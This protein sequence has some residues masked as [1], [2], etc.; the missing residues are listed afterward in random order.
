MPVTGR[1]LAPLSRGRSQ[2]YCRRGKKS[3]KQFRQRIWHGGT[4]ACFD[5][6]RPLTPSR[7]RNGMCFRG[8]GSRTRTL[9]V[10]KDLFPFPP[11]P[12]GWAPSSLLA[13]SKEHTVACYKEG[14][15]QPE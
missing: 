10:K 5:S 2:T 1:L 14:P 6:R 9:T 7:A 8:A 13:T 4:P 11:P 12:R 3:W 15:E